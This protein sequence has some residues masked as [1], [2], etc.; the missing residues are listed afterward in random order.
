MRRGPHRRA[1]WRRRRSGPGIRWPTTRRGNCAINPQ[2]TTL[3]FSR[4][5]AKWARPSRSVSSPRDRCYARS[6]IYHRFSI[7]AGFFPSQTLAH[8]PFDESADKRTIVPIGTFLDR[9]PALSTRPAPLPLSFPAD[10]W[11]NIQRACFCSTRRIP[12]ESSAEASPGARGLT[13]S[14][15][16]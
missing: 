9:G 16:P 5:G 8:V 13:L 12:S 6:R 10:G 3:L 4:R 11:P 7:V 14:S 1:G 15:S 2:P